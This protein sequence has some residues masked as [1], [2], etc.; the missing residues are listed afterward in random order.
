MPYAAALSEHPLATHAVGEVTGD[1]D[2]L[3]DTPVLVGTEAVLRRVPEADAVAFL[4]LDAEL[5]R[6]ADV[7]A[8]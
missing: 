3:P 8:A 6:L 2:R 7:A 5:R 1:S 4:D